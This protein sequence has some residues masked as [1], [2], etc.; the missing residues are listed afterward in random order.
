MKNATKIVMMALCAAL[1]LSSCKK[2]RYTPEEDNQAM[3]LEFTAVSQATMVKSGDVDPLSNYYSDFGVW[4]IAR[5]ED[6]VYNLWGSNALELVRQASGTNNYIPDGAAYWLYGYKYNF[7]AIA[8]YQS[9]GVTGV[10]VDSDDVMTVTLDLS[11]KYDE[12][13]D[14][15]EEDIYKYECSKYGF[16]VMAAVAET[17][18]IGSQKPSSQALTFYHMMAKVCVAFEFKDDITGNVIP[19]TVK[20]MRICNI[21]SEGKYSISHSTTQNVPN[22]QTLPFSSDEN[23]KPKQEEITLAPLDGHTTMNM[24]ILPQNIADCVMYLEF[25]VT[26]EDQ[27]KIVEDNYMLALSA[28]P[29]LE[30]E[31]NQWY[32]WKLII[33]PRAV[34]FAEPTVQPW[35][36]GAE[37]PPVDIK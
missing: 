7:I 13:E 9:G 31:A 20:S 23:V 37:I 6:L 16:D 24:N 14:V 36:D 32:N 10:V 34:Y 2:N 28:M 19:G 33:T 30:Y 11:G 4:G 25:E 15:V 8:P 27:T 18:V 35:V 22:V 21:D 1:A 26:K 29:V 17:D 12:A 3:P 5:N